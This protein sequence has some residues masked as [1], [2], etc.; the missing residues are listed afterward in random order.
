MTGK[1]ERF[2]VELLTL[3]DFAVRVVLGSGVSRG[4]SRIFTCDT[5]DTWRLFNSGVSRGFARILVYYANRIHVILVIRGG[6]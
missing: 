5:R 6:Y 2:K 4:F 3:R 1:G